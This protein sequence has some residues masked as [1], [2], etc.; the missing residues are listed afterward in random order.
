[1]RLGVENSLEEG[2]Q[3]GVKI[4][5][6]GCRWL[7]SRGKL[8]VG[9]RIYSVLNSTRDCGLRIEMLHFMVVEM[10]DEARAA[11]ALVKYR[12]EIISHCVSVCI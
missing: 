8:K 9:G 10:G 1:M 2:L 3:L 6:K 4:L 5:T 12:Y 7:L 11:F